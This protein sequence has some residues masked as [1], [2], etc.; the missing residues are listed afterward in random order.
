MEVKPIDIFKWD[1]TGVEVTSPQTSIIRIYIP[2]SVKNKDR[3]YVRLNIWDK[4]RGLSLEDKTL[5]VLKKWEQICAR[6]NA[7]IDRCRAAQ[8][9]ILTRHRQWR[10]TN[11]Q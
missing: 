10:G 4:L 1:I 6:K 11:G 2:G 3:L 7:E 8:K 5:S 9:I